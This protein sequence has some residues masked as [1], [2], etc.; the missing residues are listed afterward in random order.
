MAWDQRNL[1]ETIYPHGPRK[2]RAPCPIPRLKT[3]WIYRRVA[4]EEPDE[5]ERR[6]ILYD[7]AHTWSDRA[8]GLHG[9]ICT[10]CGKTLAQILVPDEP[11]PPPAGSDAH[12]ERALRTGE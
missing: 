8:G 12:L 3:T 11:P 9:G 7:N 10:R 6:R 1:A 2:H 5:A 4:S